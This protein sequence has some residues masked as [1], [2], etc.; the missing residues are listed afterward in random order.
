MVLRTDQRWDGLHTG[1][2]G[3]TWSITLKPGARFYKVSPGEDLARVAGNPGKAAPAG[4]ERLA[5][6]D[7]V[8][9]R[10]ERR[11]RTIAADVVVDEGLSYSI[12]HQHV[13][14]AWGPGEISVAGPSVYYSEGKHSFM[15]G[16]AEFIA[17]AR[18]N[19]A[20]GPAL[21]IPGAPPGG[22]WDPTSASGDAMGVIEKG[23]KEACSSAVVKQAAVAAEQA[24]I[25]SEFDARFRGAIL[26]AWRA[27]DETEPFAT[28][29]G[30]SDAASSAAWTAR[31]QLP[32]AERCALT[33]TAG[34]AAGSLWTYTCQF[35]GD[36]DI[37]ERLVKYV[38]SALGIPFR[39]D[40]TAI[41]VSQVYF[42]DP[43]KPAWRLVVTS[44]GATSQV[45]L[46]IMPRELA[47]STPAGR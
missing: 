44:V 2:L 9:V 40:E 43:A 41:G 47:V 7:R 17:G 10:G 39:P 24:R 46:R 6:G 22:F 8:L 36:G 21:T 33:K 3:E 30:D 38:Q 34:T 5:V 31:I 13:A 45:V 15:V 16:C 28:I 1:A 4:F 42:S 12:M 23:I 37:Y 26:G 20:D 25:Q 14:G 27:A 19:G 32:G 18:R 29:R 11:E 35:R